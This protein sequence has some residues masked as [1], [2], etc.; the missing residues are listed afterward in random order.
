[1]THGFCECIIIIFP[2]SISTGCMAMCG[3]H[4]KLNTK[5][6]YVFKHS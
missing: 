4:G 3:G 2:Y 1:M 5:Q 6:N